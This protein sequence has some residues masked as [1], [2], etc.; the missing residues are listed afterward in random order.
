M[1][2]FLPPSCCLLICL[3]LPL[4]KGNPGR[5][6]HCWGIPCP[7][8][9]DTWPAERNETYRSSSSRKPALTAQRQ[10]HPLLS[11]TT[12]PGP[13]RACFP[14]SPEVS[15]DRNCFLPFSGLGPS[16]NLTMAF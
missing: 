16:G 7:G 14:L 5:E 1:L 8:R 3:F 12:L 6:A 13:G 11:L 15:D 4:F 2:Y 9:M 10:Q